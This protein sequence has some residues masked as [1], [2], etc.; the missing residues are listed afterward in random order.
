MQV[1]GRVQRGTGQGSY[2]QT[3]VQSV[4]PR[5]VGGFWQVSWWEF[6]RFSKYGQGKN[7]PPLMRLAVTVQYLNVQGNTGHPYP[8]NIIH[9]TF[10]PSI[11]PFA[12]MSFSA[13]S[14]AMGH[15]CTVSTCVT[16]N[17]DPL[18]IRKKAHEAVKTGPS[19][20][21]TSQAVTAPPGVN[22]LSQVMSQTIR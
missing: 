20:P 15:K 11:Q 5:G 13:D 14:L 22:Q 1:L 7:L 21:I 6:Y 19:I 16:K 8:L 4:P 12:K 9:Y 18:I 10:N 17:G 3:P 2:S